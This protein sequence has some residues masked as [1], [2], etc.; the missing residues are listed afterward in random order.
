MDARLCHCRHGGV[1][2][3]QPYAN[4]SEANNHHEPSVKFGDV[5]SRHAEV[6]EDTIAVQKTLKAA[7]TDDVVVIIPDELAEIIDARGISTGEIDEVASAVQEATD[8]VV[9]DDLVQIIDA[10]GNSKTGRKIS[11]GEISLVTST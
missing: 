7:G 11:T 10:R 3:A 8:A 2:A 1:P 5:R 9:P 4:G 6:S